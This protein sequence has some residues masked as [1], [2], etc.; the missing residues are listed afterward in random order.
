M[1]VARSRKVVPAARKAANMAKAIVPYAAA[2][3]D[4]FLT[5]NQKLIANK[6]VS[7]LS[8][9]DKA[10]SRVEKSQ[11][12]SPLP[13]VPGYPSAIGTRVN[14]IK[15]KFST[16]QG[17]ITVTHREMFG[18]LDLATSAVRDFGAVNPFNPY[19]FPWLAGFAAGYDKYKFNKLVLE[20]VPDVGTSTAGNVVVA[21]DPSGSDYAATYLELF[22]MLS[23]SVQVWMP[24]KL[25]LPSSNEK[26]VGEQT[27]NTG[28]ARDYYNHGRVLVGVNG[29]GPAGIMFVSYSVTFKHPQPTSGFSTYVSGTIPASNVF[30]TVFPV[31]DGFNSLNVSVSGSNRLAIPSGTW[32]IE[33]YVKGT[34]ITACSYDLGSGLIFPTPIITGAGAAGTDVMGSVFVQSYGSTNSYFSVKAT[35]T[36]CTV[37]DIRLIKVD[38]VSVTVNTIYI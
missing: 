9:L 12:V 17:G 13:H 3:G 4:V 21:W 37:M 2:V 38:P 31:I 23:S 25:E 24:T 35:Y 5:N 14:S 36:T 16:S 22:N 6:L 11:F 28:V 32:K 26:Y 10:L 18:Y 19:L 1:T 7:G 27:A 29:S 30:M 15:P 8:T 34:A 20:F 33:T